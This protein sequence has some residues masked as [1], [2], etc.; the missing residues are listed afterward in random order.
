MAMTSTAIGPGWLSRTRRTSPNPT[1]STRSGL[2]LWSTKPA[3][4]GRDGAL[5]RGARYEV[6]GAGSD[7]G[8]KA[9]W[10]GEPGSEGDDQRKGQDRPQGQQQEADE[11][12]VDRSGGISI[13]GRRQRV[14]VW[15][16]QRVP[17]NEEQQHHKRQSQCTPKHR[18]ATI[19]GD[20]NRASKEQHGDDRECDRQVVEQPDTTLRLLQGARAEQDD[21]MAALTRGIREAADPDLVQRGVDLVDDRLDVHRDLAV[22]VDEPPLPSE[23]V[24]HSGVDPPVEPLPQLLKLG[25]LHDP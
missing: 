2:R 11:L 23:D 19:R 16:S 18:A 7:P 25:G 21:L 24:D 14:L 17:D 13:H 8:R 1:T 3:T 4:L 12:V 9:T 10:A 20:Q 6:A 22:A 15:A 5:P